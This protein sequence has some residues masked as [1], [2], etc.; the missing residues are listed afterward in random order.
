MCGGVSYG[1]GVAAC[2]FMGAYDGL[3]TRTGGQNIDQCCSGSPKGVHAAKIKWPENPQLARRVARNK[4][5]S[6]QVPLIITIFFSML[7]PV[8]LYEEESTRE[9]QNGGCVTYEYHVL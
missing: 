4:P 1:F 7:T 6:E 5:P 2:Y 8:R 9:L 3:L